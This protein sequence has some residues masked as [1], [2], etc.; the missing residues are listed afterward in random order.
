MALFK[1]LKGAGNLPTTKNEGWAY[2]KKTG[3]DTANFYVDYDANTRV[4]IGKYAENGIYYVDGTGTTA[5][6]W[7]GSH[8]GITSYYNGLAILYRPSVAGASTTTLNIN[9]LGART[10]YVRG[11][12]KLTTHYAV[13]SLIILTYDTSLNSGAGGWEAHTYYD[14]NTYCA[15]LCTTAAGTAAKTASHTYYVLRTGNWTLLT[16]RY[17]NTYQGKL[18]LNINGSGAKDLWI[19]GAVS[20]SSNYTLPAGTYLVYYDGTKYLLYTNNYIPAHVTEADHANNADHATS[21]D[22]ATRATKDSDGNTINSTY[23]KLVGGNMTDGAQIKFS[24]YGNRYLTIDGNNIAFDMTNTGTG[25]WAGSFASLKDPA[26]DTTTMLGFYGSEGV[27]NYIFM[28]GTYSDPAMKMTKNGVFTFKNTVNA[29]IS[30]NANT[31]TTAT[32]AGAFTSAA[33]VKLTGD[34]TG[35]ASS[36]KGW[37]VATTLNNTTVTAG[38]YGPTTNGTPGHGGTFSVPSFVV[39][40]QGRLT[41]AYTR[42]ITLPTYSAFGGAS[43]SSNGTAGLVPA[44]TKGQQGYFL[45]GDGSWYNFLDLNDTALDTISEIKTAWETAD[46]TL[47][48]TLEA[49]IGGKAPK[50]HASSATTYGTSTD[51]L[52]GHAMAS[53]TAPKAS[54]A[55]AAVGSETAKFARGDHVHPLTVA[56]SWNGGTTDGPKIITTINGVAGTGVSIPKATASAS[57]VVIVGDQTFGGIKRFSATDVSYTHELGA[58]Y[59]YGNGYLIELGAAAQSTM[60]AIHISGNS[61]TSSNLPIDSWFQFYDYSSGGILQ[62]SGINNGYPLGAMTVYRYNNKLY[63][64]I[65]QGVNYSTLAFTVYTNSK[66]LTPV[67]TNA[68]KHT[69]STSNVTTITP[70]QSLTTFNYNS[71]VPKL[72]GTGA[73]GTWNITAA[74][75]NSVAWNNITGKPSTYTPSAHNHSQLAGWS[76]TRNVTTAPNDYNSKMSVVGIKTKAAS[77]IN[78]AAAGTY[79]TLVGIRGWS[80]SSGGNTHELAFDGNGAIYHRHGA[81]T[82]WNSWTKLQNSNQAIPYVVGPTTDTA[83]VWTGTCDGFT[84]YVEGLTIIYVPGVAGSDSGV[85]LN[86]NG[87]GARTCYYSGTSKLTTHFVANTPIMFTYVGG[88]WKR[89]DYN[90]NTNTQIRIYR[91]T[92]GYDGDYPII[93]SRTAT[94]SIGTAGTNSSYTAVYGVI[95]QNGT[96]TP[97]VN[98]HSGLIKANG[99]IQLPANK[100]ITQV[101]N[102]TSNYTTAIKWL[103]GGV[104]ENTYDPQIGHHNTGDTDGAIVLLPYSTASEPWSGSVGLYISN[105]RLRW[106]GNAH[107]VNSKPTLAWGSTSTIGTVF[108]TSLQVTM[109]ANPNTDTKVTSVGNHYTPTANTASELTVDAS[110]TTAASWNSTSLVTG[111]NIQR[112][113]KGHVVGVTVDSVKM[114]ANPDTNT[115]YYHTPSYTSTPSATTTGGS[116]TNIKIGTSNDSSKLANL[117]VPVA[118][119]STPGVT[120]V[121]PAASCT[122]FTSDS[123]SVTPA[124]VKKSFS[125]FDAYPTTWAWTNGTSSGPTASLSGV[126]MTA[127]SIGAIPA[128]SS[129]ISGVVTTGTQSFAGRKTFAHIVIP[130]SQPSSLVAGSIWVST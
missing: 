26:G 115:N 84:D 5:G 62:P 38:T 76:D 130:T 18:T 106:N 40:S 125:L 80:D 50:N 93:V 32:T 65:A 78:F 16:I 89:A 61:Y 112:D 2:V 66:H 14:S 63:A 103:Q 28:G 81:T 98:P 126:N 59:N 34:V 99:G 27:L 30:G 17:S 92:S 58:Y 86:I 60:V 100:S 91:Q 95:G 51:T 57:G 20:S 53:S 8:S 128:A 82:A 120:I 13:D 35:E 117:Y 7:L 11:S 96:Y 122:T 127:V 69:S 39:N 94:S 10:C 121:Y 48:A 25:G 49:A 79:S 72:D 41:G 107:A 46:G 111:V 104:S 3:S 43:A 47:K 108:G 56:N 19:N 124:A 113:A 116:S 109:P 83:G 4:Q 74:A 110:S 77:G 23:L 1:I 97:T 101:Q 114:P 88:A 29:S 71:Y 36:T 9:G 37:T 44:P 45:R 64:W 22:T 105:S 67:V 73:T 55:T 33:T 102:S 12:T 85:T 75:A 31:A 42:T 119:G 24:K 21:A 123:G 87:K 129:S 118:T 52:Y 70:Y 6:T 54:A 68:A 15:S 90:S